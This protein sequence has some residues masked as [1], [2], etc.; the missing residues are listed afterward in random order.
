MEKSEQ[1]LIKEYARILGSKGGRA[2][3][4]TPQAKERAS[5]AAKALWAKRKQE[6]K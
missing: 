3:K 1:D 6:K 2:N 4:G 5:K